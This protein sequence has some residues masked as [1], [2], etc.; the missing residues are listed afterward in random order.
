MY[1]EESGN[2]IGEI[3]K[4]KC[5]IRYQTFVLNIGIVKKERER[6]RE[7]KREREREREREYA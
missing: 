7:R 3:D 6:E 1:R 2:P 4:E 5:C